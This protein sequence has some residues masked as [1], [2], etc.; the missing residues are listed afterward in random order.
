MARYRPAHHLFTNDDY[1]LSTA[2]QL[3]SERARARKTRRRCDDSPPGSQPASSGYHSNN[4]SSN[5]SSSSP[6]D[7]TT[8]LSISN[9]AFDASSSMYNSPSGFPDIHPGPSGNKPES[10]TEFN[11]VKTNSDRCGPGRLGSYCARCEK[12]RK[13]ADMAGTL[14]LWVLTIYGKSGRIGERNSPESGTMSPTLWQLNKTPSLESTN[15]GS[16][17]SGTTKLDG[18]KNI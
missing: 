7:R 18:W 6:F 10:Y 11:Y 14:I 8:A 5:S 16:K 4:Q 1:V 9:P 17:R 2:F 3:L 13:E 12:Y 15:G